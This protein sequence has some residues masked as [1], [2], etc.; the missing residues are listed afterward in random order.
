MAFGVEGVP[1]LIGVWETVLTLRYSASS[2]TATQFPS[3]K[4]GSL[5]GSRALLGDVGTV[6]RHDIP[7]RTGQDQVGVP[8]VS[9]P[10]AE[11]LAWCTH[12]L[13]GPSTAAQP[14]PPVRSS[15]WLK[16]SLL[17][18]HRLSHFSLRPQHGLRAASS[19]E[20]APSPDLRAEAG[21]GAARGAG[22]A[23][24]PSAVSVGP[25]FPS[26]DSLVEPSPANRRMRKKGREMDCYLRRLKQELVRAEREPGAGRAAPPRRVPGLRQDPGTATRAGPR[27]REE[28]RAHSEQAEDRAC[29]EGKGPR[30]NLEQRLV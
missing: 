19:R 25:V 30:G 20:A 28:R 9:P 24:R 18:S 1:F 6:W 27:P 21:L 5:W 17:H 22:A 14:A 23:S 8:H 3:R 11:A 7:R 13:Q 2:E 29:P 12:P 4:T 16:A 26:W 10:G 15:H